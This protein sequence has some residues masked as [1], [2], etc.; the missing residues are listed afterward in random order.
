MA[1]DTS[2]NGERRAEVKRADGMRQAKI[3]AICGLTWSGRMG[4]A[5]I[6][7]PVFCFVRSEIDIQ[8][9][10]I[11]PGSPGVR[12]PDSLVEQ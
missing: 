3:L 7:R 2:A 4:L 5:S 11:G 9:Q 8:N 1:R 6:P 10:A 12:T